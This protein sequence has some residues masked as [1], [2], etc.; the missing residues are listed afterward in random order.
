MTSD[1]KLKPGKLF[2]GF[3]GI[4]KGKD[5]DSNG[6]L[7]WRKQKPFLKRTTRDIFL[8]FAFSGSSC[9]SFLGIGK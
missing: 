8:R 5:S 9:F 7:L 2:P 4:I 6:G 1:F 3:F